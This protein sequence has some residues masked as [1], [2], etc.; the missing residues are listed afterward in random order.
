LPPWSSNSC[1]AHAGRRA[2]GTACVWLRPGLREPQVDRAIAFEEQ[3]SQAKSEAPEPEPVSRA[4]QAG[5]GLL[6]G[7]VVYGAAIGGLFSLAFAFVYGR[8]GPFR[9][10][11]DG[12]LLALAG[13]VSIVLVP[14]LKYPG[15][16]PSVGDPETIGSRTALFFAMLLI[17][18]A[19]LAFAVKFARGLMARHGTWNAVLAGGAIYLVTIAVAQYVLPAINE[20]PAQFSADLLWRFRIASLGMHAVLWATIGLAFGYLTERALAAQSGGHDAK[21]RVAR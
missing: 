19:A 16:P 2:C 6:T 21:L 17:S 8:V 18:V 11:Y 14:V 20:V 10:P 1:C 15:N 7:V 12:G 5:L 3:L 4:S 9:R 13:F